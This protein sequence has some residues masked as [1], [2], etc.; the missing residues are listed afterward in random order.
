MIALILLIAVLCRSS[1]DTIVGTDESI[2]FRAHDPTGHRADPNNHGAEECAALAER[3]PRLRLPPDT[4][5]AYEAL[6]A[7]LR[8]CALAS[9]APGSAAEG[10]RVDPK[11]TLLDD[12]AEGATGAEVVPTAAA[13]ERLPV[14]PLIAAMPKGASV[15]NHYSLSVPLEDV[16][17]ALLHF[18]DRME[19]C[20]DESTGRLALATAGARAAA[21]GCAAAVLTAARPRLP[22]PGRH[23]QCGRGRG[24]RR[25][26]L[27]EVHAGESDRR[28]AFLADLRGMLIPQP[29]TG[30]PV[31][32]HGLSRGWYALLAVSVCLR[33]FL[34][35]A[36]VV[37]WLLPRLAARARHE[38]VRYLELK[39]GGHIPLLVMSHLLRDFD[40]DGRIAIDL[41]FAPSLMDFA[42]VSCGSD[43]PGG[44]E[45]K[46]ER[47]PMGEWVHRVMTRFSTAVRRVEANSG[48]AAVSAFDGVG[49][50]DV[51]LRWTDLARANY[52]NLREMLGRVALTAHAGET[53]NA[54]LALDN[55]AGALALGA[56]QLGHALSLHR[57]PWLLARAA[58]RGVCVVAAPVSN[59]RLGFVPDLRRHPARAL[60]RAGHR[61]AL[62]ADDAGV[63]G[64]SLAGTHDLAAAAAAWQLSA[65]DLLRLARN[66]LECAVGLSPAR[67]DELRRGFEDDWRRWRSNKTVIAFFG[68]PA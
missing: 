6:Y 28:A 18:E 68:A 38:N 45:P 30:A 55:M 42:V 46:E 66:S 39:D 59:A 9:A 67:R 23:A 5:E 29:A 8:S 54:S 16:A 47:L 43:S 63:F 57:F 32:G 13:I 48:H 7:G 14:F 58:A 35:S 62:A 40:G 44:S 64:T 3:W 25:V 12:G 52:T 56:R 53:A 15:H 31:D 36:P 21:A 34:A 20:V 22:S 60:L 61:V 33:R 4:L 27:R 41:T 50:E 26:R 51:R 65:N 49:V 19:A 2:L 37:R 17:A 1:A 24:F 11:I 10:G